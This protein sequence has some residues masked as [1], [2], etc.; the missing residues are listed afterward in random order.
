MIFGQIGQENGGH[1]LILLP[2]FGILQYAQTWT[3]KVGIFIFCPR[4][5][6]LLG[7]FTIKNWHIFI[8]PTGKKYF[9]QEKVGNKKWAYLYFAHGK[10]FFWG[11]LPIKNGI[12][13]FCPWDKNI[14]GK[15]KVG[16]FFR[17]LEKMV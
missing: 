15:K 2:T 8:L 13:S 6:I 9:G 4:E 5:K 10:K 11:Y 12:F 3:K 1:Y 7:I 16:K 14:L 17:A